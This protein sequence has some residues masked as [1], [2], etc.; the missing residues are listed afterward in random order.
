MDQNAKTHLVNFRTSEHS[1]QEMKS[2]AEFQGISVTSMIKEAVFDWMEDFEDANDGAKLYAQ[3][4]KTGEKGVSL[5][6]AK[7]EIGLV[8]S[9]D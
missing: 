5:S 7:K 4:K 1:Y 9:T 3:W 8:C 6:D 2:F